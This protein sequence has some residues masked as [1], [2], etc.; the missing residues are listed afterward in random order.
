MCYH[1]HGVLFT[2]F[3]GGKVAA[4]LVPTSLRRGLASEPV[5]LFWYLDWGF[6]WR[7]GLVKLLATEDL[8]ENLRLAFSAM[9]RISSLVLE[10]RSVPMVWFVS[11]APFS[12]VD[13]SW[14]Y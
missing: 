9:L 7:T 4:L 13:K 1:Y 11:L 5:S 3:L 2:H 12:R 14:F 10:A 6:C 8:V